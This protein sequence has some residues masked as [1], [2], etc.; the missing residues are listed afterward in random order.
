[1]LPS[2]LPVNVLD[3]VT[4]VM[5]FLVVTL[6][7]TVPAGMSVLPVTSSPATRPVVVPENVIVALPELAVPAVLKV[8]PVPV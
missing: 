2:N 1:M 7:I 5:L 8:V 3:S 6:L 4:V